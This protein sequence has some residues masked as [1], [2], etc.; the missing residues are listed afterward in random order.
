MIRSD[1]SKCF[2]D[3]ENLRWSKI[4]DLNYLIM[5]FFLSSQF[6]FIQTE[7]TTDAER[8][9]NVDIQPSKRVQNTVRSAELSV[10]SSFY[11]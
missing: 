2:T 9:Q 11:T 6:C 10:V 4:L 3:D 7:H 5:K 1:L 8:Q